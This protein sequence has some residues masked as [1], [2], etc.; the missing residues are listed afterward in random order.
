MAENPTT[1]LRSA[2]IGRGL[3]TN[4]P[5]D[6][7]IDFATKLAKNQQDQA[8]ME[9]SLAR[10]KEL[11]SQEKIGTRQKTQAEAAGYNPELIGTM[12]KDQA[13]A[14]VEAALALKKIKVNPEVLDKWYDSLPAL[15]SNKDVEA[16]ITSTAAPS[17]GLLGAYMKDTV[18]IDGKVYN[19]AIRRKDGKRTDKFD[20]LSG[21]PVFP[22][23]AEDATNDEEKK[24]ANAILARAERQ[25][26]GSQAKLGFARERFGELSWQKL[27][28]K[29]N[30]SNAP[31]ARAIGQAAINNMRAD[32]ALE[33]L[34]RPHGL[35]KGE[36]DIVS[37]DLAAIFKGGVPDVLSLEHQRYETLKGKLAGIEQYLTSSPSDIDTP[38]IK[39]RLKDVTL[40]V[41]SIDNSIILNYM[42]SV[43]AGYEPFVQADPARFGRMVNAQLRN[44]GQPTVDVSVIENMKETPL[45]E[46]ISTKDG[47][48]KSEPT[49]KKPT[50]VPKY[51]VEK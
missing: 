5:A 24:E 21:E 10:A 20:P 36:Y 22:D 32:R 9:S 31:A 38:E 28:D 26:A 4:S 11:L 43:A 7:Y 27:Q 41:K 17:T 19:Q 16:F 3:D 50:K 29:I 23:I 34:N 44:L 14:Q 35:T 33:L 37:S 40:D 13:R 18:T 45:R 25:E 47:E 12:T 51:T 2:L 30:V 49:N 6:T 1:D 42:D 39:D 48:K 46:V 8:Q 15:V